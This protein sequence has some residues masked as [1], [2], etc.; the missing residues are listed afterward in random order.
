M[1]RSDFLKKAGIGS[2]ALASVPALAEVAWAHDDDDDGPLRFYFVALSGQAPTVTGGDSI[3]MSGCG[4][5]TERRVRG[6]GEF[7]HFD[8]TR[9]GDPDNV[10]ATGSWKARRFLSF[11]EQGTWGVAVSGIL[12]MEIRLLPCDGPVI[13]GATLEIVCNLAPAGIFNPGTTEGFTLAVPGL[14]PFR[15]F[16]PN[17][18]LTLFTRP[19][20]RGKKDG[21]ED[22]EEDD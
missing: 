4:S 3:A 21:E 12:R 11:H 6:G 20:R 9:F 2:V 15:A 8:G 5:F 10:I 18:G 14:A 19:C 7:V 17:I 22:G 13:R 1:E 16:M